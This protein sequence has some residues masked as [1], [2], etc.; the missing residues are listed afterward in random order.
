[1][2]AENIYELIPSYRDLELKVDYAQSRADETVVKMEQFKERFG[3][4]IDSNASLK[5]ELKMF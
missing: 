1:M 2:L 5:D 4:I 3:E